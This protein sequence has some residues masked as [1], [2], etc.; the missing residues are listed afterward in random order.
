[1]SVHVVPAV[2]LSLLAMRKRELLRKR[3]LISKRRP[4]AL[5]VEVNSHGHELR[6]KSCEPLAKI[7]FEHLEIG[8]LLR[9]LTERTLDAIEFCPYGSGQLKS[10]NVESRSYSLPKRAYKFC[11]LLDQFLILA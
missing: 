11:R 4:N 9:R 10:G 6:L 5:R 2:G 1:M 3:Y 7:L 8:H